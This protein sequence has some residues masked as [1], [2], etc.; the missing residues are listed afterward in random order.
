MAREKLTR[1]AR[2]R[3]FCTGESH[4]EALEALRAQDTRP[5][6]LADVDWHEVAQGGER[7][8]RVC[9]E[10]DLEGFVD[11]R[12]WLLRN[13]PSF[14]DTW[15]CFICQFAADEDE[16]VDCMACGAPTTDVELQV[17]PDCIAWKMAD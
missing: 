2:I 5:P 7:L 9:P 12:H 15:F 14:D 13:Q 8:V 4:Q 6:A 11:T 17:C 16:V 1:M 3:A 10:C